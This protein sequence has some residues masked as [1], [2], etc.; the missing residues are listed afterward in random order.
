MKGYNNLKTKGGSACKYC[1]TGQG[2]VCGLH[3]QSPINLLRDRGVE[4]GPHYKEC[5]DWHWMSYRDDSC[6]WDDMKDQFTIE[7]HALQIHTPQMSN[8]DIDCFTD[9]K[10]RYPRLDYSKGFPDYWWLQRTDITMPSQH[11]QEGVRYAAE[12]TLAHFYEKDHVKN[13]VRQTEAT[14]ECCHATDSKL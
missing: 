3:R 10:R 5:P 4:N 8:G 2:E 7:R 13:Q 6:S 1:P 11:L 9:N 14:T 12:V